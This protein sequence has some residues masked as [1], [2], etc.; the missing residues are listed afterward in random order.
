[1]FVNH[2]EVTFSPTWC[3]VKTASTT[4][5]NNSQPGVF[6]SGQTHQGVTL[7]ARCGAT[8]APNSALSLGAPVKETT[9]LL[10]KGSALLDAALSKL[11]ARKRARDS[12]SVEAEPEDPRRSL[13]GAAATIPLESQAVDSESASNRP[14]SKPP[15]QQ[16]RPVK[17]STGAPGLSLE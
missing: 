13:G 6:V 9:S 3:A 14:S 1:M 7:A 11:D 2:L 5:R 17:K 4:G 12:H 8:F 10:G 15:S 16:Q